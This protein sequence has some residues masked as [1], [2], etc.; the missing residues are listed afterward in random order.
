M[1]I[2]LNEIS[3]FEK[4]GFLHLP[5][6][7]DQRDCDRLVLRIRDL[8]QKKCLNDEERVFHAGSNTQSKDDFFLKSAHNISFFYDK[9]RQLSQKKDNAFLALNKVGHA[10]HNLCP[11]FKKFSHHEKLY[12]LMADLGHKKSLLVQSMFIFKQSHFGDEVPPHQDASF[13]FTEP[14]SLIGVWFALQDASVD[15]GCLWA[16]QGGHRGKL[17]NRF[18]KIDNGFAFGHHQVV[19][20]PKKNFEPLLAKA[21]DAYVLHGLLPHFSEQNR[22]HKTRFAYTLHFI[23]RLSHYAKDNWIDIKRC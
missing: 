13:L 23:D 19:D 3:L 9:N 5:N 21:G 17:K 8:T 11:V 18:S 10:L 12:G 6:F 1:V 20:W 15:N 16:L 4:Q 22:S 2:S 14:N 7:I